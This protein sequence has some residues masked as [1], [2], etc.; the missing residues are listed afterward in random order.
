MSTLYDQ[1]W[2]FTLIVTCVFLVAKTTLTSR[3]KMQQYPPSSELS[4]NKFIIAR[5]NIML[6]HFVNT[7]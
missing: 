3:L 2:I 1:G 5:Q 4:K 6:K 7:Y